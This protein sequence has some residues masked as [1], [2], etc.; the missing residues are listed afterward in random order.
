MAEC[1]A[2]EHTKGL[3]FIHLLQTNQSILILWDSFNDE[4]RQWFWSCYILKSII[5]LACMCYLFTFSELL[6]SKTISLSW[7]YD[8]FSLS[9]PPRNFHLLPSYLSFFSMALHLIGGAFSVVYDANLREGIRSFLREGSKWRICW[10][11]G[12][13]SIAKIFPYLKK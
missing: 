7:S 3:Y 2:W 6:S 4:R 10:Y 11:Y 5:Q 8:F 12:E 9:P 13:L 1:G